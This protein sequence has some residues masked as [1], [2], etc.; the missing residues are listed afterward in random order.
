MAKQRKKYVRSKTRKK[1]QDAATSY[2][3]TRKFSQ[4]VQD[5]KVDK[6][7]LRE[8][9]RK[10]NKHYLKQVYLP[11]VYEH[12][13]M[14]YFAD[15]DEFY[16]WHM[17]KIA[18]GIEYTMEA[19][20]KMW[21][22]YEH[23]NQLIITGQFQ[24]FIGDTFKRNYIKY[25][26]G[27]GFSDK[28]LESIENLTP[29]QFISLVFEPVGDKTVPYKT[30]LPPIDTFNYD[31]RSVYEET[32]EVLRRAFEERG[33][34]YGMEDDY[35]IRKYSRVLLRRKATGEDTSY[36]VLVA[37]GS[38]RIRFYTDKNGMTQA[39]IPFVGSTKGKNREFIQDV[40]DYYYSHK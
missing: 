3:R 33:Y 25:L 26:K 28:E 5:I 35:M 8:R 20:D 6:A 11:R 24:D 27:V 2:Y 22:M 23:R 37:A 40:V 18:R 30:Y 39:Y 9:Y 14:H 7:L 34:T 10:Y 1:V 32:R 21:Q 29:S 31:N 17:D 13:G 38:K 15:K 4:K 36:E 19:V 16:A 12:L